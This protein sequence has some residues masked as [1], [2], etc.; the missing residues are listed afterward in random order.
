MHLVEVHAVLLVPPVD[1]YF[2]GG[3]L[4]RPRYLQH[5]LYRVLLLDEEAVLEDAAR[6]ADGSLVSGLAVYDSIHY[7][8]HVS[9]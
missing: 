2:L 8:S 1:E 4:L 6:F 7:W 3:L 9:V 5:A